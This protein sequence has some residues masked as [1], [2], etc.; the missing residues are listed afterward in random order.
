MEID[1]QFIQGRSAS[2]RPLCFPL[3]TPVTAPGLEKEA[4]ESQE[5][6][7]ARLSTTIY[8]ILERVENKVKAGT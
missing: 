7:P 2:G 8:R 4:A 5:E 6:L 3:R 1:L